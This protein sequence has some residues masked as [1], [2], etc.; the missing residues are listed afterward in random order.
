MG[1]L[2]IT[3]DGPWW[4]CLLAFTLLCD[5]LPWVWAELTYNEHEYNRSNELSF[6]TLSYSKTESHFGCSLSLSLPLSDLAGKQAAMLWAVLWRG[7][8]GIARGVAGEELMPAKN[9]VRKLRSGSFISTGR[10]LQLTVAPTT[11]LKPS[12]TIWARGTR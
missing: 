8:R 1:S 3:C 6:L 11:W 4:H 2:I 5:A 12:E 10:R 9:H 7:P